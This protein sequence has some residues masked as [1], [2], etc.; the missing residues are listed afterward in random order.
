[1]QGMSIIGKER[2]RNSMCGKAT[3]DTT[4]GVEKSQ[5]RRSSMYGQAIRSTARIVDEKSSVHPTIKGT[6][7]LQ[8]GYS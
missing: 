8:R 4:K 2:R 3:K 7:A 1:M 6:R 5:E